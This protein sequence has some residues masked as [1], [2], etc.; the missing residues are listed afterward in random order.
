MIS[1]SLGVSH[2]HLWLWCFP[3]A[4]HVSLVHPE[5]AF[6]CG[7]YCVCVCVCGLRKISVVCPCWGEGGLLPLPNTPVS[8]C[9]FI[10]GSLPPP[11]GT[12]VQIPVMGPFTPPARLPE[13]R[14]SQNQKLF[15][16]FPDTVLDVQ[17]WV[18]GLGPC[19][20]HPT[21]VLDPLRPLL[22]APGS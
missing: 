1:T 9:L 11:V 7:D 20:P 12:G 15:L 18:W 3:G 22:S 10:G 4:P 5:V 19:S 6:G 2:S 16:C 13:L 8:C 14:R 17:R 21:L